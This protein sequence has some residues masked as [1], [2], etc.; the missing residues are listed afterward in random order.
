MEEEHVFP[1]SRLNLTLSVV[2]L[3]C[4]LNTFIY[5]FGVLQRA[6]HSKAR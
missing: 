3:F 5:W 6:C 4:Q 2:F 1:S